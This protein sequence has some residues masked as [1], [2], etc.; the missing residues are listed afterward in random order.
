MARRCYPFV[1]GRDNQYGRSYCDSRSERHRPYHASGFRLAVLREEKE[2]DGEE[3][4]LHGGMPGGHCGRGKLSRQKQVQ[5]AESRRGCFC[6]ALSERSGR[7]GKT[8]DLSWGEDGDAGT[9]LLSRVPVYLS[10]RDL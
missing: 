8:G 5:H 3:E 7:H 4:S 2:N 10:G 1:L 6:G 9:L